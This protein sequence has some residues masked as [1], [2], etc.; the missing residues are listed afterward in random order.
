MKEP[1]WNLYLEK[2]GEQHYR[3]IMPDEYGTLE[4]VACPKDGFA[5]KWPVNPH[6]TGKAG[7]IELLRQYEQFKDCRIEAAP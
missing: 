5:V 4:H 6:F 2:R 7:I 3:L 1:M